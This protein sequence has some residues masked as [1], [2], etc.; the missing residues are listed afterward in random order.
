MNEKSNAA[1]KKAYLD[2]VAKEERGDGCFGNP[3]PTLK[4]VGNVVFILGTVLS[5]LWAIC[6]MVF[7]NDGEFIRYAVGIT[8]LVG[9][10]VSAF[11]AGCLL[12][13]IGDIAK[14]AREMNRK[15]K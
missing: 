10:S 5:V 11:A 9:G 15:L 12:T 6:F 14:C 8:I 13:A 1:A 4:I 2:M 3:G 7:S